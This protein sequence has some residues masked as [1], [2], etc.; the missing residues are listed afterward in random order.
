VGRA[1]AVEACWSVKRARKRLKRCCVV[2]M[3]DENIML[4]VQLLSL[5]SFVVSDM[6]KSPAFK[7]AV[8]WRWS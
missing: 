2:V 7:L 4:A 1:R 8:T 5:L 6:W 3:D